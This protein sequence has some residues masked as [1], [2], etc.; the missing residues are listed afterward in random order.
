MFPSHDHK[1]KKKEYQLLNKEKIR[2]RKQKHYQ[3]NKKSIIRRSILWAKNN[4]GMK[5]ATVARRHANKLKATPSWSESVKIKNLYQK[6]KWL[7]S[8]TG[9]KYHVDHIIPLNGK[10]VCGLHVWDNLQIL[11]ESINCSK[12]NKIIGEL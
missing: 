3:N 8:I 4:P 9:F 12:S 11:E 2:L 10:N 6:A 7:E 5:N 1:N